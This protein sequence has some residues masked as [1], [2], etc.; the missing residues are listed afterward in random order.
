[1]TD[2]ERPKKKTSPANKR[3]YTVYVPSEEMGKEWR[4]LA[5]DADMSISKFIL[6]H[7]ENS[8]SSGSTRS[9]TQEY[10]YEDT[11]RL[12]DELKRAKE[13]CKMR[14]ASQE[15]LERELQRYRLEPFTKKDFKGRRKFSRELIDILR[16]GKYVTNDDILDQLEISPRD[17]DLIDALQT[18]L[19]TLEAY[20]I[21]TQ[22][23]KGWRW[24]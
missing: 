10:L 11:E 18:A 16:K 3:E 9:G 2:T 6:Y 5:Q 24:T 19:N 7:V 17:T 15:K 22:T 13:E 21:I 23:S 14:K 20:G 8:L 4:R 12:R 1:M